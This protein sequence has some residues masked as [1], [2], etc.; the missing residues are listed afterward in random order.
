[1]NKHSENAETSPQVL[2]TVLKPSAN[3]HVGFT[4]R[5]AA[6]PPSPN[7]MQLHATGA[8]VPSTHGLFGLMSIQSTS[9]LSAAWCDTLSPS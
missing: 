4:P 1:M 5:Y 2:M 9:L 6:P 8:S 7:P 3:L